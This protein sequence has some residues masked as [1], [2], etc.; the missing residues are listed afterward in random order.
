M[1]SFAQH[2]TM[3]DINAIHAYLVERAHVELERL[4]EVS[5]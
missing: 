2:L 5:E 4:S 3:D 1:P